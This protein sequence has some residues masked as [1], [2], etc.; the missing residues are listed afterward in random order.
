MA[1]QVPKAVKAATVAKSASST[2]KASK[3]ILKTMTCSKIAQPIGP[4]T[5]G[6][7]IT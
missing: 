1:K 2:A 3:T 4:Y 5:L 7:L 6:R